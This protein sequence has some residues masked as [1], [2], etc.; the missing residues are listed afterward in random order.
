M[1]TLM[2]IRNMFY[3]KPNATVATSATSQN[4]GRSPSRLRKTGGAIWKK[5][6][7]THRTSATGIAEPAPDSVE[8]DSQTD[9]VTVYDPANTTSTNE[10]DRDSALAGRSNDSQRS[11]E[12]TTNEELPAYPNSHSVREPGSDY[13]ETSLD[14][15][16][17]FSSPVHGGPI[18]HEVFTTSSMNTCPVTN[19]LSLTPPET[20]W[21]SSLE[22]GQAPRLIS[23][24]SLVGCNIESPPSTLQEDKTTMS[25]ESSPT[26]ELCRRRKSDSGRTSGQDERALYESLLKATKQSYENEIAALKDEQKDAIKD[27][28]KELKSITG[29][30]EYLQKLVKKEMLAKKDLQQRFEALQEGQNVALRDIN[31]KKQEV[32]EKGEEI[33][34]LRCRVSEVTKE[35]FD[36][37]ANYGVCLD[38]MNNAA[39][40]WNIEKCDLKKEVVALRALSA[41]HADTTNH[42]VAEVG[43]IEGKRGPQ[44]PKAGQGS[45]ADKGA[46]AG[47][48]EAWYHHCSEAYQV[49]QAKLTEAKK[50]Q[51]AAAAKLDDYES[52]REHWWK[53][54]HAAQE[55]TF[56][57]ELELADIQ[58]KWEDADTEIKSFRKQLNRADRVAANL[59]AINKNQ[60]KDTSEEIAA[61][62]SAL[63]RKSVTIEA[64]MASKAAWK[65]DSD[66]ILSTLTGQVTRDNVFDNL[67][68][69]A[70][71]IAEDNKILVAKVF[72][73]K[74]QI[75][76]LQEEKTKADKSATDLLDSAAAKSAE[77]AQLEGDKRELDIQVA[78]LHWKLEVS[79]QEI[80][81]LEPMVVDFQQKVNE[82]DTG[83]QALIT[84]DATSQA[85]WVINRK[86][87]MIEQLNS[88]LEE[89]DRRLN[90]LRAEHWEC[91][92]R[93]SFKEHGYLLMLYE[94]GLTNDFRQQVQELTKKLESL[95]ATAKIRELRKLKQRL[96]E[97]EM[98]IGGLQRE[99]RGVNTEQSAPDY[100]AAVI[101]YSSQAG[102]A[103]MHI[104][105]LDQK[106]QSE[107]TKTR[108]L[109]TEL[110]QERT[111]AYEDSQKFLGFVRN[112]NEES[113][114]QSTLVCRLYEHVLKLE[115]TLDAAGMIIAEDDVEGEDLKAECRRYYIEDNPEDHHSVAGHNANLA[116]QEDRSDITIDNA[117]YDDESETAFNHGDDPDSDGSEDT[118]I[119]ARR[120][121]AEALADRP[122]VVEDVNTK[123]CVT[124]SPHERGDE[125]AGAQEPE[126]KTEDD[127]E[128]ISSNEEA[129]IPNE[130]QQDSFPAASIQWAQQRS[131]FLY[132]EP[133]Q[134]DQFGHKPSLRRRSGKARLRDHF[135]HLSDG[136][137]RT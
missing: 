20:S 3:R 96:A 13:V 2:N 108:D 58:Q 103:A 49:L 92:T 119:Q 8:H 73:Q 15:P 136:S 110:T 109:Q 11:E 47:Q 6:K 31:S 84:K 88:S 41:R 120:L 123:S 55:A 48:W 61:L 127:W 25:P 77:I 132:G 137:L 46:E 56:R 22:Q 39:G 71:L 72:E 5:L 38:A 30:K 59:E 130:H 69:H 115:A 93:L 83:I 126:G 12:P 124:S 44:L 85:Q 16:M 74:A 98:T 65:A 33:L 9:N 107:Q 29:T 99:L 51:D 54:A 26:D 128:D 95:E 100:K 14:N 19:T 35:L 10:T 113:E 117:L 60:A 104:Q 7:K 97:A 89:A 106:L 34:A 21:D 90:E 66:K 42:P 28:Q 40:Q 114:R 102:R 105:A 18:E 133:T 57:K 75:K 125:E 112:Q 94:A 111:I 27:F 45:Q 64:L 24:D 4:Q 87:L 36:K 80:Q 101:K 76:A 91:E 86:G 32:S 79:N 134:D 67:A 82:W 68:E 50:A 23:D 70:Q 43:V 122:A 129:E 116:Q 81:R 78:N 62:K 131:P 52:Q 1:P 53:E 17:S 121:V 37:E 135:L 118:T 63:D